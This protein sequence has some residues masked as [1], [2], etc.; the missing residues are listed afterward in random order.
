[1]D[2][3][4]IVPE[5]AAVAPAPVIATVAVIADV[6]VEAAVIATTVAEPEPTGE[7]IL[8][9]TP[10][11][12]WQYEPPEADDEEALAEEEAI[13][14][15]IASAVPPP[16]SA[17]DATLSDESDESDEESDED[18]TYAGEPTEN[19]NIEPPMTGSSFDAALESLQRRM[20]RANLSVDFV[21][22]LMIVDNV[23]DV[24]EAAMRWAGMPNKHERSLTTEV[25]FALAEW[26]FLAPRADGRYRVL[27]AA[28]DD[29]TI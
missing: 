7:A 18:E 24:G 26:G 15:P 28:D 21:K 17:P 25:F 12:R 10:P 8:P 6:P 9:P 23:I 4:D 14:T 19:H 22:S 27:H 13:A 20:E 1:M 2:E 29:P 3:P 16:V 5:P 11:T